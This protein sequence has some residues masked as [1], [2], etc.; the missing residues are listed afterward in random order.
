MRAAGI[1]EQKGF[2]SGMLNGYAA[3]T[4]CVDPNT[5]TRSSSEASFLQAAL[6]KT[7]LKVYQQTMAEKILFDK[8]KKATGVVVRTDGKTYTL[9]A[10]K[11]IIVSS[12]AVSESPNTFERIRLMLTLS[13]TPLN[14]SWCP[15]LDPLQHLEQTTSQQYLLSKVLAKTYGYAPN[16]L[17]I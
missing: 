16:L 10:N 2:N 6:R 5:E 4:V 12:G 7:G 13:F 17:P 8:T 1:K 14:C 9:S 15:A 11:E 3:T